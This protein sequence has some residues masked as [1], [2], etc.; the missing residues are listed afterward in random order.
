VLVWIGGGVLVYGFDGGKWG[1]CSQKV[2]LVCSLALDC[3]LYMVA[4]E[5]SHR[6]GKPVTHQINEKYIKLL[7][8][9]ARYA[10]TTSQLPLLPPVAAGDSIY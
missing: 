7:N 4:Y 5:R 1:I 9:V 10:R 8:L 3:Q 2:P 6:V